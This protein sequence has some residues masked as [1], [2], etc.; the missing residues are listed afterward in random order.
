MPL[1]NRVLPTQEIVAIPARGTFTGNRGV[2]HDENRQ[3]GTARW[4]HK[5]WIICAL[6][7]KDWRRVPMTPG[8]WTE[9]FFLDEAVAL[10]AGHRPCALCRRPDYT[11][12]QTAWTRAT[13]HRPSAPEMDR[14]LHTARVTRDRRQVRATALSDTLPDGA[15]ALIEDTPHLLLNGRAF[16]YTPEGY[17]APLTRMPEQVT[18]LTPAP[19]LAVLSAGYAPKL[20]QSATDR[21]T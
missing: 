8:R 7:Y 19:T 4:R 1:Q 21:A 14:A 20:H 12:F 11:A 16:P 13:G 6:H 5:A 18:V 9:L 3:L 2:L 15:F 10:A 17:G